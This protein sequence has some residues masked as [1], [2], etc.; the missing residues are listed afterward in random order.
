MR[1]L[2]LSTVVTLCIIG[3][4][5][6]FAAENQKTDSLKTK[7]VTEFQK[8]APD[9]PENEVEIKKT[10]PFRTNRVDKNIAKIANAVLP[11]VVYP[12]MSHHIGYEGLKISITVRFNTDIDRNTVIAGSTVILDF[13]KAANEPGQITWISDREFKWVHQSKRRFDI[14]KYDPDCEF[15]L[16]LTDGILSKEGLRLDG[17]NDNKQGG[18]YILWFIDLG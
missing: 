16:T 2:V 5:Y 6:A 9:N 18:K 4:T 17:D 3:I 15:K 14:C 10:V 1:K 11:K 12:T 8:A 7:S 13:P